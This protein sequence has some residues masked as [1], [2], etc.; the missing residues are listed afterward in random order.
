M[1]VILAETPLLQVSAPAGQL[2]AA[3]AEAMHHG[4]QHFHQPS[5]LG[6]QQRKQ[7]SPAAPGVG[8]AGIGAA[9]PAAQTGL[10]YGSHV[11]HQQQQQH[12]PA[13]LCMVQADP[14]ED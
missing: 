14:M 8:G 7:H 5:P 9:H 2:Q 6:Q 12:V 3:A 10:I 13:G 1:T 11:S 4:M